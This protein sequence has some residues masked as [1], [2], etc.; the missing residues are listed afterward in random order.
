[1]IKLQD[2]LSRWVELTAL[3]QRIVCLV[4]S[5]TE[6]LFDLGLE[7]E[8]VGVTKFCVHPEIARS[9]ARVGGTKQV[10]LDTIKAL[11]PD[12]IIANKEEN[13]Q[14]QVEQLMQ[15]CPVYMS[16]VIDLPSASE[17]MEHIGKLTGTVQLAQ[18]LSRKQ[19]ELLKRTE[20]KHRKVLYLIWKDPWMSAGSDTY[21]SKMMETLGWQNV[22]MQPRYPQLTMDEMKELDPDL[23]LLSSEPYPFNQSHVAA[24]SSELP[25]IHVRGVDGE[26]FSWYGSRLNHL[27]D[28]WM[29]LQA[30]L[31]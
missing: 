14:E 20:K 19:N 9:K 22:Q 12:L 4:P 23:I 29:Q 1:M 28:E 11:H 26:M 24:L 7:D 18:E 10:K 30:D 8:V 6:L 13:V 15:V 25:G 17:M 5:I 31:T 16:D 21:I 27:T 2:Q 3:P